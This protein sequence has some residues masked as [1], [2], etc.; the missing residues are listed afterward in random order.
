MGSAAD[1]ADAVDKETAV[2]RVF[3]IMELAGWRV[4]AKKK[5]YGFRQRVQF[6]NAS[7]KMLHLSRATCKRLA[8]LVEIFVP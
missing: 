6:G 2:M 4:K 1:K 3:N 8:P 7:W 5:L